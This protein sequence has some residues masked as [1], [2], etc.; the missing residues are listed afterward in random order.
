MDDIASL[1]HSVWDCKYHVVW[2]PKYRRKVLFGQI[3]K[4]LGEVFHRLVEQKGGR[5]H[6]GHLAPDHVHMYVSIP[7]EQEDKRLDQLRLLE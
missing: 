1:C 4:E 6:E 5:I 7:Q 3:R 2:I